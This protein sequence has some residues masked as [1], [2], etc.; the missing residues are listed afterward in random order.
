MPSKDDWQ[1]YYNAL[2]FKLADE[3]VSIPN[4]NINPDMMYKAVNASPKVKGILIN[5]ASQ[6]N[7]IIQLNNQVIKSAKEII[8]EIEHNNE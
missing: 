7:M 8:A 2:V 6:A 4:A 5:A 1:T 3:L